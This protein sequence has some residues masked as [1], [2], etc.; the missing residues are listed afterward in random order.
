MYLH[1]HVH[2]RTIRRHCQFYDSA[3][4]VDTETKWAQR[5]RRPRSLHRGT[6]LEM[7][8]ASPPIRS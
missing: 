7:N 4:T 1:V 5:G 3:C 6:S 2:V 8:N